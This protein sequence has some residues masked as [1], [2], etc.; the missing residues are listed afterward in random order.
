MKMLVVLA[1]TL[2]LTPLLRAQDDQPPNPEMQR[3]EV[4]T[5]EREMAR[6]IQQNNGTFF[7][8]TFSDDFAGTLSHGQTVNRAALIS[9]VED[10]SYRYEFFTA[11]DIKV[12]L[13]Q[14]TAIATC[15][16]TSQRTVKGQRISSQ[17]RS[18]HIYIN[19]PRGWK[20]VASQTTNLPPDTMHPL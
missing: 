1:F 11:S 8:R 18:T 20:V 13:F 6:A 16:W 19:T 17:M 12:R 9:A 10:R 3:E 2:L 7:R 4:T 14:E 5:L 15:L